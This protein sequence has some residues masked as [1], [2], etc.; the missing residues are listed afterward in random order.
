MSSSSR[1]AVLFPG[2]GAQFV[3][4]SADLIDRCP[5][6]AEMFEAASR[7]MGVDLWQLVTH[8]PEETLNSTAVSQPAIFVVSIDSERHPRGRSMPR[9]GLRSDQGQIDRDGH[10][11]ALAQVW[12]NRMS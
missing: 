7:L 8:G 10:P 9:F 3:G 6:T 2:Q 1:R 4:M 5:E 12:T 11:L